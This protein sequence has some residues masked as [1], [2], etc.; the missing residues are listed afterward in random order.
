MSPTGIVPFCANN[1]LQKMISRL[2]WS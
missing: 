1:H 2:T